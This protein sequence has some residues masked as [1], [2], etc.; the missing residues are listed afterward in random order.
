M[1]QH[2]EQLAEEMRCPVCLELAK[3]TMDCANCHGLFCEQCVNILR[4]SA[5]LGARCPKCREPANF[6]PNEAIRQIIANCVYVCGD[7]ERQVANNDRLVHSRRCE[8]RVRRCPFCSF[9]CSDKAAAKQHSLT[10]SAQVVLLRDKLTSAGRSRTLC[11][12]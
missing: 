6:R 12:H 10:H 3:G 5:G 9:R 11:P 4:G 2:E 8:R 7:C 1:G